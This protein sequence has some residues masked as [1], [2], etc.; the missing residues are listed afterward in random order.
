MTGSEQKLPRLAVLGATGLVGSRVLAEIAGRGWP[1]KALVRTA[2]KVPALP[3]VT[4]V[5]VDARDPAALAEALA[6]VDVLIS[7]Y[8]PGWGEPEIRSI[9]NA[10]Y[11]AIITA[12]RATRVRVI[13]VGGAG[14]LEVAPGVQVLDT[15]DFP[16]A[17]RAGAEG[18]RDV[19][20]TLKG[21][22]GLDWT[23]LSPPAMIAPGERTGKYRTG[24]DQLLVA[25]DGQ[26]RISLEDL[27]VALVDE[28]VN[29]AFP[30]R[31]FTVVAAD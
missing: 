5:A 7:A 20:N 21:E 24:G 15:P 14:S 9:M 3:G 1:V 2:G 29:H 31:R 18:A 6:D 23:F 25:S 12:A 4:A 27:A 16:A 10:A 30:A 28:A 22:T 8:N 13:A 11:A 19:L 26:S 17:Y